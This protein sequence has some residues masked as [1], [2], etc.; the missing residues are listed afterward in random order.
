MRRP[1]LRV[2]CGH[3]SIAAR[4]GDHDAHCG[5]RVRAPVGHAPRFLRLLDRRDTRI[6]RLA[7]PPAVQGRFGDKP[8]AI[9]AGVE[10]EGAFYLFALPLV[11]AFPFFAINLAMGL[12]PIRTRT[13]YWVSQLGMLPGTLLYVYAGTQLGQFQVTWQLLLA[14][15]ALGIFP[16]AAKKTLDASRRARC[17]RNGRAR[18]AMTGTSS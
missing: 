18:A 13:F 14:L 8:K 17:T 1:R 3:G 6:P 15:A 5:R 4:R 16:L 10:K 12:T 9:N 2:K 11:P 7:L